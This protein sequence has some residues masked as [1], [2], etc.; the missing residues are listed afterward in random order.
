MVY[1]VNSWYVVYD[2]YFS[3]LIIISYRPI[4]I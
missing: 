1:G 4:E 2:N 3:D